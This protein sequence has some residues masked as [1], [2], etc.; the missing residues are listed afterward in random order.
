VVSGGF[1]DLRARGMRFLQEAAR[2]GELTVVLWADETLQ[3]LSGKPS[4]FPLA[5]RRYFLEAVRFVARVIPATPQMEVNTLPPMNDLRPG[6]WVDEENASNGARAAYC[7][8]R[9][10]EDRVL[11][12]AELEGFPEL[13]PTPSQPGRKKVVAT[14]CYD[15]LHSGH[16][17]FFE[18]ASA[19]GD[20]YVFLGH[21]ANI[22][23]LK[24]DGHPLFRQEERRYAVGAIKHVK[25]ALI[26]TGDGWLDADPDI[27]QLK[28]QIYVVNEDG[29]KG[30]KRE[31]CARM[32][33]EYLV[34]QRTPAAGLPRRNSTN[35]RGF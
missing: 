15:W 21:D 24:G 5:E 30:G 6:V 20:L 34:L 16:V 19:Y 27:R 10:L 23:L 28:P 17:R 3:R 31:Y 8:Q 18:E 2:L 26:A 29:D 9:H 32:G 7:R 33:L 13:P 12:P 4:K 14:G 11:P 25:Q 1:D 35:L 22:R